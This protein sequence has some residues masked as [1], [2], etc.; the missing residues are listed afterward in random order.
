MFWWDYFSRATVW[1]GVVFL[2]ILTGITTS[3]NVWADS[4]P[5]G[6]EIWLKSQAAGDLDNDS[7]VDLQDF[8]V[9]QENKKIARKTQLLQDGGQPPP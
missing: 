4:A 1:V 6:Y 2:A 3:G 5:T 9:Y 8:R 7:D